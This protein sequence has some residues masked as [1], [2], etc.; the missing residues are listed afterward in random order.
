MARFVGIQS[1]TFCTALHY[2][3]GSWQP[4]ASN[5]AIGL[6]RII[7]RSLYA[8]YQRYYPIVDAND[9]RA[10]LQQDYPSHALHL[11]AQAEHNQRRV[12]SYVFD[13]S[14]LDALQ[15]PCFLLP[16]SLLLALSRTEWPATMQIQ[17]APDWFIFCGAQGVISQRPNALVQNLAMF[18]LAQGVSETVPHVDLPATALAGLYVQGLKKL[19][20]K[21][22]AALFYQA[23]IAHVLPDWRPLLAI[24]ALVLVLHLLTSSWLV[25]WQLTER[26]AD[27]DA[28]GPQMDE[29]LSAQQ[30]HQQLT[31]QIS[32]VATQQQNTTMIAPVWQ[33]ITALVG[34]NVNLSVVEQQ[35]LQLQLR[36]TAVRATDVLSNL[37]KTPGVAAAVFAAPTRRANE[38]E[39][40]HIQVTL[41]AGAADAEK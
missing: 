6:F 26:Q 14:L 18:R 41:T 31:T 13:Q 12:T 30:Q 39:Q 36:G 34:A 25:N 10:V 40:F 2:S 23:K 19:S 20:A 3:N 15:H 7:P 11:I 22:L 8:E 28:L 27:I 4:G 17:T 38:L 16:E 24:P 29:L 21:Q 32:A 1:T 37:Q 33:L 5:P 35:G 9:L